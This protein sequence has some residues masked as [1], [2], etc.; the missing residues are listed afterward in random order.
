MFYAQRLARQQ[1]SDEN[2]IAIELTKIT[3]R[4]KNIPE[5]KI[6]YDNF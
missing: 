5:D 6:F 1:K 4:Y 2:S 3:D